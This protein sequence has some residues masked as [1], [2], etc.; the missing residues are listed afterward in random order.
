MSLSEAGAPP[1]GPH[2][3]LPAQLIRVFVHGD[4]IY[5]DVVRARPG[6]ILLRA[7]N[8]TLGDIS[9]VVERLDPGQ[10]PVNVKQIKTVNRGKR[11]QEELALGVG[12]YV[13][14]EASRPEIRGKLIIEPPGR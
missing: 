10:V 5:P 6:E 8:E 2:A 7:E 4:G 13:Y 14:Y 1:Q 12:E 11:A 3:N 9:L